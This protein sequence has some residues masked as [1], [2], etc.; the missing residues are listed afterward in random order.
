MDQQMRSAWLHDY[1]Y[2]QWNINDS[3][4][5]LLFHEEVENSIL[6][7]S[8]P[9][10]YL[11]QIPQDVLLYTLVVILM[12]IVKEDKGRG[13]RSGRENTLGCGFVY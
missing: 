1:Y 9:L 3:L 13:E 12:H 2:Q 8:H 4:H 10:F 11:F 6:R 7:V 5:L